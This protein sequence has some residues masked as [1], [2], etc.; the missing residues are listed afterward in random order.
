MC[1]CSLCRRIHISHRRICRPF[2]TISIE[3]FVHNW[4]YL[5]F[6]QCKQISAYLPSTISRRDAHY[7]IE[8]SSCCSAL[9]ML[10]RCVQSCLK[11]TCNVW[12]NSAVD[13]TV[14]IRA[15]Y[16][17]ACWH[18]MAAGASSADDVIG[19][20][21]A[22]LVGSVPLV[23]EECRSEGQRP[24]HSA[25][26]PCVCRQRTEGAVCGEIHTPWNSKSVPPFKTNSDEH[27][28]FRLF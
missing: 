8:Y 3:G 23:A 24:S 19:F 20:S 9:E 15:L 22:N 25:V 21:A 4:F 6:I 17:A 28:G 11:L 14:Q 26:S 2:Y 12:S 7:S 1:L 10:S 18:K 16:I 27:C 13:H 5:G